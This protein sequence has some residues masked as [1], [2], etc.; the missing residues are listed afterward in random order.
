MLKQ[1]FDNDRLAKSLSSS[2]VWQWNILSSYTDVDAAVEHTVQS[3]K[4]NNLSLSALKTEIV[5]NKKVFLPNKMEDAF[6]IKL[7]DLFIRRIYKVRQS[8]RNR[9]V[10]QL[11]TLLKDSGEYHVLRLDVKD[12]YETI[13]FKKLINKFENQFIL[14]PECLKLLN[15]IHNDLS[16]NHDM[17]GL[18]R[19][20]SISS[21]LAELYLENL[22]KDI[23]SHPDVIYS[24]RYVDD[25]IILVASGQEI[26]VKTEIEKL[27]RDIDLDLNPDKYYCGSAKSAEFE[28]LGY[29]IKVQEIMR[30]PNKV[31]LK[32]SQPKVNK[33]KTR[34]MT[35]FCDY[36]KDRNIILLKRRLEYLSMLKKV[37]KGENGN[38]LAGIAHNYQYV[39][40]DFNCLKSIDGFFCQQLVNPRFGLNPQEQ[41]LVKKISF[42]GNTINRKVGK[43][44]KKQTVQIMRIWKNA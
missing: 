2:D 35:S 12:C 24:A 31:I 30:K 32:I 26:E 9:I 43:F 3:W 10:R 1:I 18:P 19:G 11:K 23:A 14:A 22:D 4:E 5:N 39:T 29:S 34:I 16:S 37:K 21:T 7:L 25:L 38:L 44:S 41:S 40:D 15:S 36:K 42:F 28:L 6:A 33:L 17:Q 8:D 13:S 27:M 20:L